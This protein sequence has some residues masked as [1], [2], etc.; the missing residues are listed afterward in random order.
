MNSV[1]I[2]GENVYVPLIRDGHRPDVFGLGWAGLKKPGSA[3][4]AKPGPNRKKRQHNFER[5][6]SWEG[7]G[8]NGRV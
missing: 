5:K 6:I 4:L 2:F 1:V 8:G 7:G 3:I